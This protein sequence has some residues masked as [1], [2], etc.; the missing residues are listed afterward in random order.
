MEKQGV[1]SLWLGSTKSNGFLVDYINLKYTDNDECITSEFFNDFDIDIDDIDEDFI[2]KVRYE[3]ASKDLDFL[4]DGCSYEENVIPNIKKIIRGIENEINTVILLYNFKY[5]GIK[6]GINND[7]YSMTYIG[8][9]AY[10]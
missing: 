5:S 4:L 2:E 7:D 6:T 3:M 8:T 9:V 10:I 1:V